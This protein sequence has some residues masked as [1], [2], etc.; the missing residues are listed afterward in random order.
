VILIDANL[1]IYA[2][3][4]DS[5]HHP[6]ARRWLEQTLSSSTE[7][8]LAWIVI[9]AFLRITTRP[10]IM[11]RALKPDMHAVSSRPGSRSHS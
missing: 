7:V 3:T 1:L 9:L 2:V 11:Q 4:A 8:R 10:G 5:A 6:A